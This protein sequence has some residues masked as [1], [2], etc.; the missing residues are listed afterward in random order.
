[1]AATIALDKDAHRDLRV[2]TRPSEAY[3]DNIGMVGVIPREFP[4]LV[5]HYPIFLRRTP[6]G[7]GFE[8]GVVLGFSTVENLFLEG[9]RWD[10]LYVPLNIQRQ[11]FAVTG[12]PGDPPGNLNV[13]IDTDSP[14][15]TTGDGEAV[16]LS[17]GAPTPYLQ[18]VTAAL[19]ELVQG[20]RQ[21]SDYAARLNALGLIEAVR[22]DIE[23]ADRSTIRLDGLHSISR[24]KLQALP[25]ATLAE[26]RDAGYLELI[27]TQLASLTHM[28]GL[29][30]RKNRRL[31]GL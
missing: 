31:T 7:D 2:D 5:A 25:A 9:D 14:R 20:T 28:N 27:Y 24:D 23:F 21:G 17:D 11:P 18:R 4:R 22:I 30:A 16:F 26:L 15:L 10:A 13:A 8:C 3:G 1:M 12:L 6:A 19:N 29:V